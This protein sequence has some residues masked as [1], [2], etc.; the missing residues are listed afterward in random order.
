MISNFREEYNRN[1][2]SEQY[3]ALIDD[4]ANTYGHRPPFRIAET[5]LFIDHPLRDRLV[6]ACEDIVDVVV[7]P[8]FLEKSE[9]AL[10]AGQVVPNETSHTTFLQMDFGLC[11]AP[12]E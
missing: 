5:P 11:K 3:Q 7:Q 4:I 8:D 6:Q 9:S 12:L 10:L 1:F 2:S